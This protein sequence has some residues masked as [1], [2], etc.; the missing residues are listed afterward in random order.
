MLKWTTVVYAKIEKKDDLAEQ[1]LL[2]LHFIK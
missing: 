2:V 1:S